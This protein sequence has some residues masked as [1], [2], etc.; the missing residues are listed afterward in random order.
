MEDAL[1][2]TIVDRRKMQEDSRPEAIRWLLEL[3]LR[4][5][6]MSLEGLRELDEMAA[7]LQVTAHKLTQVSKRDELLHDIEALRVQ[8]ALMISAHIAEN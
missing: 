4:A 7:K 5:K 3:G 8:I 1:T 2:A 6:K